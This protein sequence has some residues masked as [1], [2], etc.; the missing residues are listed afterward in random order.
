[1]GVSSFQLDE[2]KRGFS[3]QH[4][5]PLDMRMDTSQSFTAWDIVNTY[6]EQEISR[7]I[8][9]YGEE[10]WAKRIASFI[11]ER[12]KRAPIE[13]TG[14]LVEVIKGAIPAR[15]RRT[16]PHPAKRVFQAL[17]IE[18]NN[19]MEVLEQVLQT[20]VRFLAPQGRMCIISFHSLEDRIVK[21]T[22]REYSRG[23]ICPPD[24]PQ[25]VCGRSPVLKIVTRKPLETSAGKVKSQITECQAENS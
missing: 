2:P 9:E 4:D 13:T 1:M 23:C 24:F 14:E 15:A 8:W 25:C 22:F 12:R 6:S 17:R 16:G 19:E 18:V 10:K 11:V 21:E 3:Y 7:V 5:A 20:M